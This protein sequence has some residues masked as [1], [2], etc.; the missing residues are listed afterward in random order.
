MAENS[1]RTFGAG[2]SQVFEV[3]MDNDEDQ[4]ELNRQYRKPGEPEYCP[5][6]KPLS[7]ADSPPADTELEK[8]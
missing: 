6:V 7:P 5:S 1:V 2:G 3:T 4:D 8:K